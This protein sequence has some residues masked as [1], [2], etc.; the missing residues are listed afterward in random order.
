M[1]DKAHELTQV[2]FNAD[3]KKEERYEDHWTNFVTYRE[4]KE[5]VVTFFNKGG[6]ERNLYD[7]IEDSVNRMNEYKT[8][9]AWKEDW[10]SNV[11]DPITRDKLIAILSQLATAR[12]KAEV[13][14]KPLSIFNT[15]KTE[16]RKK[17]FSDLLEAA[18]I[19]NHDEEQL[20]WEMYTAM[21][22]G[23]V[24]GYEGW[25]KDTKEVEYVK[26]YD[27]QTGEKKSETIK[28]DY[29]DDVF[30]EIVPIEEWFPETIWCS[31]S[32]FKR[33]VKRCYRAREMSFSQFN[34]AYG[35]FPSADTVNPASHFNT[36]Q[37]FK[38]GLPADIH[39][40]NVFV[41][42]FYDEKS[43]RMG[44]WAN[45]T[46]L[47]W[48]CLPFNHKRLPFWI[49]VFEPI[50]HQFLFGKSLPDKLM[51]MQDVDN[52]VFNGMLDQL[53]ISL[54]SP[55]F[56]DGEIDTDEG[57]LEPGRMIEI[58]PGAKIQRGS[59]G[60]VDPAA[61]NMLSLIKRSMEESSVSA[62]AQGV[63]TGGRKTKFEV[64]Q[65]QEGALNLASLFLQMMER[66]MSQKY[67]LRLHNILQYYSMPSRDKSGK[68]KFKYIVM[69]DTK[70]T[71]GKRGTKMM[72]I[73]GSNAEVPNKQAL[74]DRAEVEEGKPFDVMESRVEPIVLSR[75]WLI[76]DNM[77][78]EIK[79]IPNSSVK[80]S[81]ADKRNKDI[82]FYQATA[83]NPQFNQEETARDFARAFDKSEDIVVTKEQAQEAAQAAQAAEGGQGGLPGLPGGTPGQPALD[84]L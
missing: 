16:E 73:V 1:T 9:P 3:P 11:F 40:K 18:N 53:F 14:V 56:V 4:E 48:G 76:N 55:I 74:R 28:V 79:I 77:E 29:W 22:E 47:Y 49:S 36:Q 59:L 72:Q 26:D 27:P 71:N 60:T 67:W 57:Y 80:Q 15:A 51:G 30:G 34:D 12:M 50:H 82:A 68:K 25:A 38:W 41:L 31:P 5:Q 84:I 70:L 44:I 58:T 61:F 24:I 43:D 21:S 20:I 13:L 7:Y 37:V 10:Q 17:V 8:K 2:P 33:K 35:K 32:N 81:E 39:L 66:A 63:P 52:A 45:G 78:L 46:E 54:N 42:E 6:K 69:E 64:Q 83:G 23:T 62:Q 75:D 65:L 19:K